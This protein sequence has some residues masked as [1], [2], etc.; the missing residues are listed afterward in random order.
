M[1]IQGK[2]NNAK[3]FASNIDSGTLDQVT[4]LLKQEFT[5]DSKIR[6]MPDCHV[7]AGCVIGTTMT[8]HDKIVPN[9]VGVDIGCGMFTVKIGKVKINF[10]EFD[11]YIKRNIPA[12]REVHPKARKIK[13]D[14]EKLKFYNEL[15][16]HNHFFKSIGT[17]G[18]GNHFIEV[19]VD[20]EE[21]KYL[22]VHSGSRNLGKQIAEHYQR[23]AY[24]YHQSKVFDK[25]AEVQR[26]INEYKN[27][28]KEKQIQK[29][30][31]KIKNMEVT[32]PI[33]KD[34]CYL[35]GKL[36]DDYIHD[37]RIAQDYASENRREMIKVLLDY[38]RLDLQDLEHFETIHNYI[39]MDD[40]ILRKGAISAYSGE[41]VLIPINMRDGCIIARGKGNPDYNYSAPHGAGRILSRRQA[42]KELSLMDFK[43]TMEGIYSSTITLE[44]LDEAPFAYKPI[45]DIL[46]NIN[47]TV[48]VLKIIKPI[49]NFKAKE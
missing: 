38:F 9:L 28:K 42:Q 29:A 44:T 33:P 24:E 17:L 34:L 35:E 31:N 3:V 49:Y 36:F 2:Y 22:I 15:K 39:N 25:E 13:T 23:K 27:T 46:D 26:I 18:G 48:E 43:K 21:N 41:I 40:M 5:K 20:D 32:P 8:I 7:G 6:I 12:G 14:I 16:K 1:I 4:N 19:D 30:I 11:D 45:E 47:D 37:M 10:P